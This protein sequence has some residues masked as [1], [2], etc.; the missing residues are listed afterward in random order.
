MSKQM[1]NIT[2]W[3]K[4]LNWNK[5][6][7]FGLAHTLPTYEE[8]KNNYHVSRELNV[9]TVDLLSTLTGSFE[10][11]NMRIMGQPGS[12]KTSYIYY[13]IKESQNNPKFAGLKKFCF[14]VMHVNNVLEN[15]EVSLELIETQIEMA[16]EQYYKSCDKQSVMTDIKASN[17][18]A[19]H[20][21]LKYKD[22][23]IANKDKFP[24]ILI[25][26]IDD[27]DLLTEDK[28]IDAAIGVFSKL[29]VGSAKKWLIIR[30]PVYTNYRGKSKAKLN[31]FFPDARIFPTLS[32]H[33]IIEHRINHTTK[34]SSPKNPFSILLCET[35]K[36]RLYAGDIRQSLAML[37]SVLAQ[38]EPGGIHDYSDDEFL[39]KYL[40][41]TAIK[42]FIVYDAI[43]DVHDSRY[44]SVRLIPLESELLKILMYWGRNDT[45]LYG[46]VSQSIIRKTNKLKV[47]DDSFIKIREID[48]KNAIK[49]LIE[50]NLVETSGENIWLTDSGRLVSDYVN[51]DLYISHIKAKHS[52]A[53]TVDALYWKILKTDIDYSK[54]VIEL[55]SWTEAH[56]IRTPKD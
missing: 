48:L 10:L 14:Y 47:S 7:N 21:L 12:G 56:E 41:K 9:L 20:K 6:P 24:K 25:F 15:D 55:M 43:P 3:F 36:R 26:V 22:Y 30:E 53:E 2:Q 34:S 8:F 35:I 37:R 39:Q 33:E 13:L 11:H 31:T 28:L 52:L 17:V 38:A 18:S 1:A 40:E 44:R 16:W 45:F 42:T 54:L 29:E 19:A 50:L 46:L 51:R 4:I 32:L 23:F 49:R 27:V 5:E